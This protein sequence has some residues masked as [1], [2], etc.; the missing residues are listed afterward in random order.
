MTQ[1]RGLEVII[2]GLT[3][4]TK[5]GVSDVDSS[6]ASPL[7]ATRGAVLVWINFRTFVN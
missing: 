4:A 2:I 1:N 6:W 3:P 5:V 7:A